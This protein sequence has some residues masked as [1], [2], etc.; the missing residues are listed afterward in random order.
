MRAGSHTRVVGSARVALGL[1]VPIVVGAMTASLAG[2]L[3]PGTY[4]VETPNWAGQALGQDAV[5][6]VVYPAMAVLAWRAS[7]GSLRAYLWWL[8]ATAYSA[9]SYLLYAGFVHFSGW[10]LVY[11]ATFGSSTVALAVG[12]VALDARVL[13]A[14]FRADGP[15]RP[16]GTVLAG[17]GVM[18][19]L[20][21]LSEVVPAMLAGDVPQGVVDAGLATNPVWVLDLGL[22]L[23]AMTATGV[24][25]R[26][27]RARGYLLAGPLLAFGV[28]MGM[29]IIGMLVAL[30]LRGGPVA[31]VPLAL[32]GLVVVVEA[33]LMA[34]FVRLLAP[35]VT[36][37]SVLS[38]RPD[39]PATDDTPRGQQRSSRST[40]P[41]QRTPSTVAVDECQG[42][43]W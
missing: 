2:L 37:A 39:L 9:Y 32:M 23:P 17:L 12:V 24:L 3:A 16:V 33:G 19:T 8:G 30:A 38:P 25:L 35:D 15:V 27:G 29:A 31:V 10:F 43:G 36:L 14:R 13:Q 11:V 4:A 28:M 5:N 1:T 20:L 21:W 22:V 7:R 40:H 18:F 42:S 34:R 26:R 41:V 6:L